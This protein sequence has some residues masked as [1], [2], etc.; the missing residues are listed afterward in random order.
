MFWP[1]PTPLAN[2]KQYFHTCELQE[3]CER[4][5]IGYIICVK[6]DSKVHKCEW[7]FAILANSTLALGYLQSHNVTKWIMHLCQQNKHNDNSNNNFDKWV[8]F[9]IFAN[10]LVLMNEVKRKRIQDSTNLTLKTELKLSYFFKPGL[11]VSIIKVIPY[12]TTT[13][14]LTIRNTYKYKHAYKCMIM[15][16]TIPYYLVHN[17]LSIHRKRVYF[18]ETLYKHRILRLITA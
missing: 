11:S 5:K 9:C 17:L 13:I 6:H 8:L 10:W 18:Q 14:I 16:I 2:K 4:L 15:L 12:F 3:V 7:W 1:L